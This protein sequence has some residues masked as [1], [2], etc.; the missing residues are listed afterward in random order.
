MAD[1]ELVSIT[2]NEL[3]QLDQEYVVHSKNALR[4]LTY[5]SDYQA[6]L[7]VPAAY[8]KKPSNFE[9]S[10]D[11]ILFHLDEAFR[12]S[13]GENIKTM[14]SRT[15]DEMFHKVICII[16]AKIDLIT[17]ENTKGFFQK[18]SE[19]VSNFVNNVIENQALL[20]PVAI[21]AASA[22]PEVGKLSIAYFDYLLTKWE[23][24]REESYF[25]IQLANVY[26][27][28]LD[29]KSFNNQF[30]LIRNT[31]TTNK[32]NILAHVICEK[33]LTAAKNL[34]KFD[35]R[36]SER[37]DSARIILRTLIAINEWKKGAKL[38][39][40]MNAAGLSNYAELKDEFLAAYKQFLKYLKSKEAKDDPQ[41]EIKVHYPTSDAIKYLI[42]GDKAGYQNYID[43]YKRK[44]VIIATA[45]IIALL[46]IVIVIIGLYQLAESNYLPES[47]KESSRLSIIANDVDLLV[48]KQDFSSA[49]KKVDEIVWNNQKIFISGTD[50]KRTREIKQNK[51]TT[52]L[53]N[54][55]LSLKNKNSLLMNNE[56]YRYVNQELIPIYNNIIEGF[57][58]K[59][60]NNC[61]E[62]LKPL[63]SEL[64][65]VRDNYLVKLQSE[66]IE[67]INAKDYSDALDMANNMY[68]S[69][70]DPYKGGSKITLLYKDSYKVHWDK[71]KEKLIARIQEGM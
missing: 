26:Q 64:D 15:T 18:I 56:N 16:K 7:R 2:R 41:K 43:N 36:D 3:D 52:I 17:K 30:G 4:D 23:T 45:K 71:E 28:I 62:K 21:L 39:Y 31:F 35:E 42:N 38:L 19:S 5:E 27:K 46:F 33:G 9:Q 63:L 25:Y 47:Q 44:K 49:V 60:K 66:I 48:Q 24:N 12:K 54:I 32:K 51:L 14:V 6:A 29:S 59:L 68:H 65:Q 37:Q 34:M 61:K 50:E 55:L 22:S 1:K 10:F 58:D 40:E 69:S 70:N 67:K 57:K 8:L 53:E 13:K 11:K 20:H